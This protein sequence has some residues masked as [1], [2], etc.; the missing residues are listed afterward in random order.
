MSLH[1][2]CEKCLKKEGGKDQESI[3]S[4]KD[5][6]RPRALY[7]KVLKHNKIH[8]KESKEVSHF[9]ADDHK[10]AR[11]R[12]NNMAKTN[13]N[14][15]DQQ[16]KNHF[17]SWYE[18]KLSRTFFNTDHSIAVRLLLIFLCVFAFALYLMSVYCSLVVTS[19]ER[20]GL[21]ALLYLRLSCVFVTFQYG[22]LGQVWYLFRFLICAFSLTL[23]AHWNA[24]FYKI[25]GSVTN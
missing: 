18:F 21:L 10:A 20:A 9:P 24:T 23:K 16:K 2:Y 5:H 4:Y 22:V 8:I 25:I 7:E 11:H 17:G 19:W 15:E 12:Q 6:T 3:Q 14:N 13:T 1:I